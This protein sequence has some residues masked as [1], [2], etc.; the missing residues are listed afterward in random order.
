M[1]SSSTS[2]V[3]VLQQSTNPE[4]KSCLEKEARK[5]SSKAAKD[6]KVITQGEKVGTEVMGRSQQG[7]PVK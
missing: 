3:C 2:K 4:G 6:Y 5:W 1:I 7:Q